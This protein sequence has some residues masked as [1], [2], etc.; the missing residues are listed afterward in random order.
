MLHIDT[1]SG[2]GRAPAVSFSTR[3]HASPAW[4]TAAGALSMARNSENIVL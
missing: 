2:D 4:R 3:A 1:E